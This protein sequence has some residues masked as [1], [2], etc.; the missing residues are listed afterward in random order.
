MSR[1]EAAKLEGEKKQ[2]RFFESINLPREQKLSAND[3][4]SCVNLGFPPRSDSIKYRGSIKSA[5][6]GKKPWSRWW[7]SVPAAR[8]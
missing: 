3:L 5:R 6:I 1:E 8:V 7:L 4:R 2:Y